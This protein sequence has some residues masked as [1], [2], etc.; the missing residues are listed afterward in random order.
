MTLTSLLGNVSRRT[1]ALV[2]IA[3]ATI[4]IP[5]SLL[6][7]GPSRTTYTMAHPADK[8]AFNSITDNP[9]QGDERNFVQIRNVTTNS[10]FGE[11]TDLVAGNTYE[12]YVF[13]HNDAATNLNDKAHNYK[14]IA[15]DA[16]IKTDLPASVAAGATGRV[17]GYVGASNATPKEVWDEA[18]MK[19]STAGAMDIN[20][21][22]GSAKITN[23]GA[24]NGKSL[25]DNIFDGGTPLGYDTLDGKL[26]GCT[27]Y[28]GYVTYKFTADQ[29]N[30]TVS[31]TVSKHGA[32]D[33]KET[34]DAKAG[35]LVDFL[36]MY[37]N[38]GSTI[39]DNVIIRD[40]LPKN[41]SYVAN[42]TYIANGSTDHKFQL[43]TN[44][45]ANTVTKQGVNIQS[46]GP[47]AGGFIKFTAKVAAESALACG[48][49]TL[50]NIAVVETPNGM[51][52]DDAS[53]KVVKACTPPKQV[54]VCDTVD[55]IITTVDESKVDG[56]RFTT[57]LTKC[58]PRDIK[59][60]DLQTNKI[61]TVKETQ[62]DGKRYT[63]DLSKCE[64]TPV[65]PETP[66]TPEEPKELPHTGVSDNVLGLIG[67]GSLSGAVSAYVASRRRA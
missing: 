18:Y 14:G 10:K 62:L 19:N 39:Q 15:T 48:T 23:N 5:A 51:K 24:A 7:W 49:N 38:T 52:T 2:A 63:T 3:T 25:S 31:K 30:F 56:K 22:S 36:I 64:T 47:G 13:Y 4:A 61:V 27:Q 33:F 46:Y 55:R 12:V 17:N 29:P 9:V 1:W 26:P 40:T 6:A 67:L 66:K 57:D 50:K 16:Y 60:C 20:I 35:D 41:L 59:A 54:K 43:V 42:S 28:S 32:D 37:K 53:V 58:L 45:A 34:I 8:V 65:T 21:V 11:T 44:A